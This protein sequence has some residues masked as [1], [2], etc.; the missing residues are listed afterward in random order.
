MLELEKTDDLILFIDELHTIVG[1]GGSS[2]SL[3]ASNMFKP[4]LARGDIH[5]IGATTLD[6]YRRY[7]EKDGALERRFQIVNVSPPSTDESIRILKGLQSGYEKH[8]NVKYDNSAIKA[9]VYL[10]H[11]YISDKFLPDKAIDIM[12]EAGSR[13]H[14]LNLKVPDEITEFEMQIHKVRRQKD[15]AIIDQKFE[16]AA[17]LRDNEQKLISKLNEVK[18]VWKK[19]ER[20]NPIQVNEDDIAEVVSMVTRIPVRRVAESEGQKLL[21]I[22][23]EISEKIIGQDRA[24]SSISKAMQRSRAG[25]KREHRPIGV[26]LLLGPTGVGKTETAKVL[27]NYLFSH[28]DSLIK[29]DMS[30]YGE[31]F[32]VSRLIG[33]PPGYVGY[34]EGGELTEKV[35][36]NPYSVILFDE[37]EKAHP[38]IFNVLLQL[39]DEGVL[40]DSLGRKVD[41]RNAIIILTSNIGT[42]EIQG[43]SK[44]GFSKKSDKALSLI[45]I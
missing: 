16:D 15:L 4:A 21:K 27:A 36:R 43:G 38:D 14:M 20:S 39:F 42:K 35:R 13:S 33:A 31:R 10:S 30:E 12:D 7:I 19:D 34:E 6:E 18:K 23:D 22:K 3:D 24:L 17:N 32:S 41:F 2:G 25:L 26:F 45:H 5:C 40:T 1:A 37:I 9:C 8:H 11:R 28:N 29:L 44:I